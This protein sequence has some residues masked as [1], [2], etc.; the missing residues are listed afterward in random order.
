MGFVQPATANNA[1]EMVIIFIILEQYSFFRVAGIPVFI[2]FAET[3]SAVG[4]FIKYGYD[5]EP[6]RAHRLARLKNGDGRDV[7]GS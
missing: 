2:I 4:K 6:R 5:T 3:L 1:T 7:N